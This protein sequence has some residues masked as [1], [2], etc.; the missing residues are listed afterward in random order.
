MKKLKEIKDKNITIVGAGISGLG[1]SKLASYLGAKVTL[2]DINIKSIKETKNYKD[3]TLCLGKYPE[4]LEKC[5]LA[6]VSPGIDCRKN[7]FIKKMDK[8]G[9]PIISEIE[10]ASWFTNSKIIAITG[11]NGKSTV[12]KLLVDIFKEHHSNTM[13]GGNIGISFSRNVLKEIKSN[14]KNTIHILEISSFQLERVYFFK[15]DISCILNI[16]RDHLDRY[17]N[18]KEYYSTKFK[19]Y[20]GN[21]FIYNADDKILNDK[22][23]N[24][25]NTFSFSLK[26]DSLFYLNKNLL[27]NKKNEQKFIDISK[28]KLLGKH[29]IQNII[30]VLHISNKTSGNFNINKKIIYNFKPLNHRLEKIKNNPTIIND[31][32]STN[33][34]S[35]IVALKSCKKNINL[36]LGGYSNEIINKK[37]I[38]RVLKNKQI[39]KIICYGQVGLELHEIIKK[40]ISSKFIKNFHEAIIFAAKIT[41]ENQT[42]LLSPGFKSFDQFKN[43]EERGNLFKKYIY[44]YYEK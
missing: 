35:T 43:Y 2:T 13:P 17:K 40:Y 30:A 22:F 32:K 21:T 41:N 38:L 14:I 3:I 5:E 29:N 44:E 12:V 26:N 1:A 25:Q 39:N 19:I 6:I 8:N 27:I 20:N 37:D 15:P 34:T 24:V 16:S 7:D 9:I 18:Y 11:S 4:N 42:L 31:S 23:K 28:I 10:F 33:L 36:I